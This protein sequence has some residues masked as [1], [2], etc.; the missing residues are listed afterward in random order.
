MSIPVRLRLSRR[1]GF[2]LQT[3]SLATNGLAAVV[4]TRASKKWGNP[5]YVGMFR[6]Y[7]RADAVRDFKKWIDGDHGA[8][9]WAGAPP[10]DTEIRASLRGHNLAC[11]CPLDGGPCHAD[12]LL[13]IAN[14]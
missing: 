8:R 3:L 14:R 9:A 4:V 10:T 7:D 13:E 5:Y 2:R 6:D 12:V 1:K 11:T